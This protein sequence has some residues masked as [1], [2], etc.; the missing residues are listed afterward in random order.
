MRLCHTLTETARSRIE[1]VVLW[2]NMNKYEWECAC[3]CACE[4][5]RN[6]VVHDTES[7]RPCKVETEITCSRVSKINNIRLFY[8]GITIHIY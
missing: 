2:L 1:I 4:P 5:G 7:A 8:R 6:S 3:A